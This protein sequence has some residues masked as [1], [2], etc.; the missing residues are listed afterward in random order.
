MEDNRVQDIK[1]GRIQQQVIGG[2]L[3]LKID[4][5]VNLFKN[6]N[7]KEKFAFQFEIPRYNDKGELVKS[8]EYVKMKM[9]EPE[10]DK[11]KIRIR[12]PIP[13]HNMVS[14]FIFINYYLVYVPRNY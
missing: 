4:K 10:T 7:G 3:V 12:M 2:E 5:G 11:F 6:N 14:Q 9:K 8:G 13:N 1:A